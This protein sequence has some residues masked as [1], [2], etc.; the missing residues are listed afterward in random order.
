MIDF[1]FNPSDLS[2]AVV[3]GV[4]GAIVGVQTIMK[5][6]KETKT[7]SNIIS[8][9][10]TELER[11]STQNTVL[12]KELTNLQLEIIKLNKEIRDLS[13]ENQK[14][15]LEVSSINLEV[16]QLREVIVD[17]SLESKVGRRAS[18]KKVVYGLPSDFTKQTAQQQS[19]QDV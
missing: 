12:T 16:S 18:D 11:M 19:Q 2:A 7:E 10:H 15:Y 9:M 14:L 3:V 17:N 4:I 13:I 8:L 1:S 6:W 5:G